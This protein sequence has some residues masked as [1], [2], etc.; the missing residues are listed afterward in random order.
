MELRRWLRFHLVLDS[1]LVLLGQLLV[2]VVPHLEGVLVLFR[3]PPEAEL[4]CAL[5]DDQWV[6]LGGQS[7]CSLVDF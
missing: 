7:R 1:R 2:P 3:Q 6:L 4:Q 5:L